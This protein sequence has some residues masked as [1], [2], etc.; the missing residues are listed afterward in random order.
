M[1]HRVRVARRAAA[2]SVTIRPY[3][4][5]D[6]RSVRR[7]WREG[8]LGVGPSDTAR[9]LERARRRD[10]DLFLVAERDGRPV[11]VVLGRFDGRRGWINHLAVD[12]ALRGR[13][14]G[15]ALVRAVE[16]RLRAK[17]CPKVNLHVVDTNDAVCAFYESLGY[18][19]SRHILMERWLRR[20]PG[21][22]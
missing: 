6:F 2:A 13:G 10:P 11:G 15:A 19:R 20:R 3:G 12:R 7:L 4:P 22:T 16:R 9:E 18:A 1:R 8:G 14:I 17:G 21:P 5:S